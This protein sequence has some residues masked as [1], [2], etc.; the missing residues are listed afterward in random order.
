MPCMASPF[1]TE[2]HHANPDR[3]DGPVQRSV[4]RRM[5]SHG[6]AGYTALR[7]P[8]FFSQYWRVLP[9]GVGFTDTTDIRDTR[10]CML[11]LLLPGN[12]KVVLRC[13]G[14]SLSFC[15]LVN[16]IAPSMKQCQYT[17]L[18]RICQLP[19]LVVPALGEKTG[20]AAYNILR[21]AVFRIL[22]KCDAVNALTSRRYS[23]VTTPSPTFWLEAAWPQPL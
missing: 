4:I 2:H 23:S 13:M 9:V 21:Y 3:R 16:D 6:K 11:G 7:S 10:Q 15:F 1:C 5:G 20:A 14:F 19:N 17:C 22:R 8:L 18:T 12:G